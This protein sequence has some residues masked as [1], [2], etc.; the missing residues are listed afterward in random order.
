MKRRAAAAG[1]ALLMLVSGLCLSG[2]KAIDN[3]LAGKQK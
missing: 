1:L 2:L 3:K